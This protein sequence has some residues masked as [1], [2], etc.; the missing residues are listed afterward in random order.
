MCIHYRL[1]VISN[2]HFLAS[3]IRLKEN[4]RPSFNISFGV[5]RP[6]CNIQ[7]R[8]YNFP[9]RVRWLFERKWKRGEGRCYLKPYSH[10]CTKEGTI[11]KRQYLNNRLHLGR[12][13]LI[14][15]C[16]LTFRFCK[17]KLINYFKRFLFTFSYQKC[18]ILKYEA[19]KSVWEIVET[20]YISNI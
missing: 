6:T 7:L 2:N 15:L 19:L 5:Q 8:A 13:N 16:H 1:S 12:T 3:E 18:Y 4:C 20:I 14:S 10:S 17:E 11:F 9:W